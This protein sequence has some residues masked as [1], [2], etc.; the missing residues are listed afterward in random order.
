MKRLVRTTIEDRDSSG[1]TFGQWLKENLEDETC[2][3]CVRD[4]MNNKVDFDQAPRDALVIDSE[5]D[6]YH[7]DFL[8]R[9]DIVW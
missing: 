6:N 9:L 4:C 3:V 1:Q 8:V 2:N 7:G 5:Y